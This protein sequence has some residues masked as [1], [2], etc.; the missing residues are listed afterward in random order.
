MKHVDLIINSF[1]LRTMKNYIL[2]HLDV[3]DNV[4]A[5]CEV[6]IPGHQ[7]KIVNKALT[8]QQKW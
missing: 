2:D 5:L 6:Q 1:N 3:K 4:F 7:V 8:S